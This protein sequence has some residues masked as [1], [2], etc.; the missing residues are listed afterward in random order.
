LL[1]TLASA[2]GKKKRPS[3]YRHR[4]AQRSAMQFPDRRSEVDESEMTARRIDHADASQVS[5][6]CPAR[7]SP[8]PLP[9]A[10]SIGVSIVS[11]LHAAATVQAGA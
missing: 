2:N 9:L 1:P 7:P 6:G 10:S 5:D 11:S 8:A 4:R 3:L